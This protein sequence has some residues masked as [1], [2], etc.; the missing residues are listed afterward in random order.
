VRKE[1]TIVSAPTLRVT[2]RTTVRWTVTFRRL[3]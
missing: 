1:A 3:F 2:Q